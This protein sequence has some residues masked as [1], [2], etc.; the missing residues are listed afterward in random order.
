[1]N[2]KDFENK[3]HLAI[4]NAKD[5]GWKIRPNTWISANRKCCCP[6]GALFIHVLGEWVDPLYPDRN[7]KVMNLDEN[8]CYAFADGFDGTWQCWGPYNQYPTSGASYSE[9]WKLGKKFRD[10]YNT[11]RDENE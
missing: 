4:K 6:L 7:M 8:M 11:V 2:I 10:K 9:V 5:N 3:L 1:M